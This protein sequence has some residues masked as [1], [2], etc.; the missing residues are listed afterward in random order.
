VKA[1]HPSKP[2]KTPFVRGYCLPCYLVFQLVFI[3]VVKSAEK[4]K[5]EGGVGAKCV[6]VYDAIL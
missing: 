3:F 2:L 4:K 6:G 1:N 5:K